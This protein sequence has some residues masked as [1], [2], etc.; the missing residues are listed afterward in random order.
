MHTKRIVV[1]VVVLVAVAASL[2]AGYAMQS[3]TLTLT[4]T[5]NTGSKVVE[6]GP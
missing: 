1:L 6:C 5:V 3:K 2:A 4:G